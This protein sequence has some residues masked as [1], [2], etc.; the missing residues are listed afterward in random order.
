MR[1]L[2]LVLAGSLLMAPA[3]LAEPVQEAAAAAEKW[4]AQVDAGQYGPSWDD[5]SA[6]F[7]GTV[8]KELWSGQLTAA[9]TPL[10][11]AVSRQV[12]A[13]QYAT[14]LPGV[15]DGEY[16]V[17]QYSSAFANKKTAGETVTFQ[18][19]PDGVWRVV[20]YFIR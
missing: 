8:S 10:G 7:R 3:A 2:G 6:Y 1:R 12:S 14:E 20:G 15:P 9:R 4:L 16:V 13:T 17:L 11:K 19:E 5:A 18:K